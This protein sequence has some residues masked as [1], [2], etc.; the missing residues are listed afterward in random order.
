[1]TS[2]QGAMSLMGNPWARTQPPLTHRFPTDYIETYADT[3][4]TLPSKAFP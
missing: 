4:P 1:M 2:E 3:D